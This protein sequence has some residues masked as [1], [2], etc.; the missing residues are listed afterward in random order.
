M[1]AIIKNRNKIIYY[2][3]LIIAS[4]YYKAYKIKNA[5]K[6]RNN[7][8]APLFLIFLKQESISDYNSITDKQYSTYFIKWFIN[9]SLF[10]KKKNI[11]VSTN[12]QYTKKR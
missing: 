12:K 1:D 6:T 10:N 3:F 2:L 11:F 9:I 5:E 4:K 7:K 8:Q